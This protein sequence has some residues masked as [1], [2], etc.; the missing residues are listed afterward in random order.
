MKD[1]LMTSTKEIKYFCPR[2]QGRT[3][4]IT[5]N[6]CVHCYKYVRSDEWVAKE[7]T[8]FKVI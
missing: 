5:T 4:D 6:Y 7:Q 8:I 2:C 3:E 1:G